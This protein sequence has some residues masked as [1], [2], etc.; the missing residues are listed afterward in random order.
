RGPRGRRRP[1]RRCADRAGAGRARGGRGVP[2]GG[3]DDRRRGQRVA[4]PDFRGERPRDLDA[5]RGLQ[6]RRRADRRRLLLGQGVRPARRASLP[7]GRL[8]RADLSLRR[9]HGGGDLNFSRLI[10]EAVSAILDGRR[11][12]IRSDGTPERDYLYVE[13]AAAAYL[14]IA[15][16]LDEG[17]GRGEAFNAG[18]GRPY[19]VREVLDVLCRVA[20]TDVEPDVRGAGNPAGEIDRQ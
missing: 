1:D 13:D 20:G 18:A 3:A 8:P 14:A 16:A 17:R 11:P 12:V 4:G 19:S 5:T 15:A 2:P 6:A 10:P 7:R 9:V